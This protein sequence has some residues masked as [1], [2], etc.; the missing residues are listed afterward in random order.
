MVTALGG[1]QRRIT[2][3]LEA[4]GAG[5][6]L[7]RADG[8]GSG[9]ALSSALARHRCYY[10]GFTQDCAKPEQVSRPELT[11]GGGAYGVIDVLVN[12]NVRSQP[13][14]DAP[15]LGIVPADTSIKVNDCLQASDG[16]WCRAAFGENEGW[17]AKTAL[18]QQEWPIVTYVAGTPE[19][20]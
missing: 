15:S 5:I 13:R 19:T 1:N 10:L 17:L 8:D 12:L 9:T 3:E 18:R 11:E 7:E 14:R 4:G 16:I 6:V 2:G 20:G